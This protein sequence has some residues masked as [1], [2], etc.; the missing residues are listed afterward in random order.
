MKRLSVLKIA[1]NYLGTG[2]FEGPHNEDLDC[3]CLL[4]NL[5]P[6]GEIRKQWRAGYNQGARNARAWWIGPELT[7]RCPNCGAICVRH[8]AGCPT[9]CGAALG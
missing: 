2:G 8:A 6:C 9:T 4:T 7:L 5:A 3:C 1:K